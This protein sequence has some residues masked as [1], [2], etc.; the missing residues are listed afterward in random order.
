MSNSTRLEPSPLCLFFSFACIRMCACAWGGL[1][2]TSVIARKHPSWFFCLA[3][4]T[5]FSLSLTLT[6]LTRWDDQEGSGPP[7]PPPPHCM[8]QRWL[9]YLASGGSGGPHPWGVS[10]LLTELSPCPCPCFNQQHIYHLLCCVSQTNLDSFPNL[11]IHSPSLLILTLLSQ[12]PLLQP[13]W[14]LSS[15]LDFSQPFNWSLGLKGT[16]Q[17]KLTPL[18]QTKWCSQSQSLIILRLV[19][20]FSMALLLRLRERTKLCMSKK[21]PRDLNII[22]PQ[23][24]SIKFCFAWQYFRTLLL[25]TGV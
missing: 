17:P 12:S 11:H 10:L 2:L 25:Y 18:Q 24:W 19:Q 13:D 23:S 20:I 21:V 16:V 4:E 3:L 5:G 22:C 6:V 8:S 9:F 14:T 1:R 15:S 7:L